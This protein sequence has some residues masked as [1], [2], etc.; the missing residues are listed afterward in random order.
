MR[1]PMKKRANPIVRIAPPDPTTWRD[2]PSGTGWLSF[3]RR[4]RPE[5]KKLT[6][7]DIRARM[8][9]VEAVL[10]LAKEP[11]ISRRISDLADLE[12]G[13]EARTL[14]RR[15]NRIYDKSDRAFRIESVAG[16][17]QLL[18]HPAFV[19]WLRKLRH[20]PS[21][22]KLT[23]PAFETLTVVAYRQPV[24]RADI[25]AIRGVSCGEIL[26]QLLEQDLV[27]I[28]GRS[29]ELGRP[30]LY[31]T[32][33]HFLKAFGLNNLD[34]LPRAERIRRSPDAETQ[35]LDETASEDSVV[36]TSATPL[37]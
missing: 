25:E 37:E 8:R 9:R 33:K 34:A 18:T 28:S 4:R 16:G 15:L 29:E 11:L 22:L 13:T 30:F 6:E 12:D 26:K 36:E 17:Y 35:T 19:N 3:Q 27:R 32:T 5:K 10:F 21:E 20:V 2:L 24:I 23:P 31:S 7:E 14:I 1:L